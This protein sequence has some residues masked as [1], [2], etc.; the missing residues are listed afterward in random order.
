[1]V[2]VVATVHAGHDVRVGCRLQA[3]RCS[4]LVPLRCLF[5]IL[6]GLRV[7]GQFCSGSHFSVSD[8]EVRWRVYERLGVPNED[9]IELEKI[10]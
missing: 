4:S 1:M 10:L 7:V 9:G 5:E 8:R 3:V 2:V 6:L